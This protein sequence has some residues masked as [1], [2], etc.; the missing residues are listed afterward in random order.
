MKKKSNHKLTLT[1][2]LNTNSK[3]H[4]NPKS[5]NK[6]YTITLITTEKKTLINNP[7]NKT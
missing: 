3:Q 6:R 2:I 1:L 7:K 4:P 5:Q